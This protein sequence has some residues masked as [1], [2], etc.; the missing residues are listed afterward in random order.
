[1]EI[2]RLQRTGG[3]SLTITLPKKW[4]DDA[5]LQDKDLVKILPEGPNTLI[6]QPAS[7]KKQVFKATIKSDTLTN[8]ILEREILAQYIS[9]V[10]EII[11]RSTTSLSE[12]RNKIRTICNSLIGF[13]LVDDSS[14]G[15]ILKNIF[16]P[17]KFPMSEN[18][19]KMFLISKSMVSDA[20]Q[21][22]LQKDMILAKDLVSR[23]IEID[24]LYLAI[25]RQLYVNIRNKVSQEESGLRETDFYYY[26]NVATQLERIADHAVKIGRI[27]ASADKELIVVDE[28]LVNEIEKKIMHLLDTSAKMVRTL[29][30]HLAHTVLDT[31]KA[32]ENA[33]FAEKKIEE[34]R[35]FAWNLINDS[36]D[37][38]RGYIMNIAEITIDQAVAA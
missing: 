13:E 32:I 26:G 19:E 10:D 25:T 21:A 1:M 9:G 34:K 36:F 8:N 14:G 22:L 20:F 18:I 31:N 23:D 4:L 29:D 6:I 38:L 16:D 17:A 3:S 27:V 28:R 7:A 12:Q 11:I 5:K 37:R 24:K 30:K 33:I 35:S 2:R 15:I